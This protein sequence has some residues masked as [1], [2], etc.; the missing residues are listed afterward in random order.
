MIYLGLGVYGHRG[1]KQLAMA[2]GAMGEGHIL[3]DGGAEPGGM[4]TDR[5]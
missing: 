4:Q 3:G 2:A 1:G 5:H